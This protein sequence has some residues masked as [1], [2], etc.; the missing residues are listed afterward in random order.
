[1]EFRKWITACS[2]LVLMVLGASLG[3]SPVVHGQT[4][5]ATI[6]VGIF[7]TQSA[8]NP[9][10]NRVY[11]TNYGQAFTGIGGNSISVI[12][13][14][15]DAVVAT[16][17]A[18]S[19]PQGVAVN[20]VTNLVYVADS[21]FSACC[22]ANTVTV[23]NG[24]TN[25]DVTTITVGWF[26]DYVAVNTVTNRVYVEGRSCYSCSSDIV[27]VIDG[28]TNTVIGTINTGPSTAG[29]AIDLATNRAYVAIEGLNV[30]R[31]IDLS[32]NTIIDTMGVGNT[33][34]GVAIDQLT[35][36]VYV[37][38]DVS[39]TVSVINTVTDAIVA[40]VVLPVMS[41]GPYGLGVDPSTDKIWVGSSTGYGQP[42]VVSVIDGST[43]T[44]LSSFSLGPSGCCNT[45]EIGINPLTR[46]V[47]VTQATPPTYA[48]TVFVLQDFG[49]SST[50]VSCN[51]SSVAVNQPTQCTAT[52]TDT[53]SMPTSPTGP[54]SFTTSSSGT[55]TP[56]NSCSLN[57][58]S[59]SASNCSVSY[60]PNPGSE[61]THVIT[62]TYS[63][64]LTHS[65]SSGT[66]SLTV[67][68]CRESDG[69]G[70][71]HSGHGEGNFAFDNDKCKDGDPNQVSSTNRGDGQNFQSTQ[72]TSSTFDAATNTVTIIGVGTSNGVPVSFTFVAL[73]TTPT[74][75]GWVSF[76]FSDGYTTAG[77]LIDGNILLH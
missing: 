28:S 70:D 56:S 53:S 54:V 58:I 47:Y 23:I 69:N 19:G 55:F 46:R 3:A 39:G 62:G 10:T 52:V 42:E 8:V 26:P 43:N 63:G 71:F 27:S 22:I 18:G 44:V 24:I 74:T 9:M 67:T 41:A 5:V 2:I 65:G 66:F 37:A 6:P 59:S 73:E 16:V 4:E 15:T 76:T 21:G 1:M 40:T 49:T 20:P 61:G 7:P 31:V 30:I 25:T 60:T 32:T 33:P 14:S 11:V 48:G 35:N 17:P 77:T 51:P 75:P 12:D 38:N 68:E 13:G 29:I 72:I 45:Q 50:S 34:V 57:P 36:L 64:D